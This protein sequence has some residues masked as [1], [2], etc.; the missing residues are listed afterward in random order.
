MKPAE[1]FGTIAN[2]I[3]SL[4]VALYGYIVWFRDKELSNKF[5]YRR[6]A[7]RC[8]WAAWFFWVIA[9]A[10]LLI[11]ALLGIDPVP[12]HWRVVTLIFDN[13]NSVF[14][15]L[16]YFV[17]TRGNDFDKAKIFTAFKQISISLGLGCAILYILSLSSL[18]IPSFAYVTPSFAYDIHQTWSLCI[19]VFAPILVGWACNLR[20][21]TR[22]VLIVGF[23]YGFMQ[24]LVYATQL[25][26]ANSTTIRE[27]MPAVK[28]IVAM[29]LGSLKVLW[30]IV[31][32]QVLTHGLPSGSSLVSSRQPSGRIHL[33]R[34]RNW[35]KK[36][37]IHALFLSG[38]YCC[39]IIAFIIYTQGLYGLATTL[40]VLTGFMALLGWFWKL[41][42]HGSK[43]Q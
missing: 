25:E 8:W 12:V 30:A 31:F 22:L 20:Y 27:H 26:T 33:F 18:L 34:R 40:T 24:P 3:L 2:F 6:L 21:N 7:Y 5:P 4:S 17:V 23:A 39:L 35:D 38:I 28:P 9:W 11:A 32:T 37:L 19:G 14:T 13:L 42:D 15:I 29:T 43:K 10:V 36:V 1:D 16:V 41:W